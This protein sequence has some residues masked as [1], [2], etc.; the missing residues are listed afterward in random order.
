MQ[1]VAFQGFVLELVRR[2]ELL[3]IEADGSITSSS[4]DLLAEPANLT[5]SVEFLRAECIDV[6]AFDP[7]LVQPRRAD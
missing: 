6:L 5:V 2:A 4:A 1:R 3:T 7:L